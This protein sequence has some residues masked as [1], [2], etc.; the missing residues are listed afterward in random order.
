MIKNWNYAVTLP[1]TVVT[2]NKK[3]QKQ[4]DFNNTLL[5]LLQNLEFKKI[6]SQLF[7]KSLEE[8][9]SKENENNK[10]VENSFLI[11]KPVKYNGAY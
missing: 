9:S 8:Q 3:E 6:L 5:S 2:A 10:D 11:Y 4:L 1:E 7:N